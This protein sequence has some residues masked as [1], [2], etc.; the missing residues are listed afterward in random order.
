MELINN[1][2]ETA[3]YLHLEN[4][5]QEIKK[6]KERKENKNQLLILPVVG[7]FSSGKTT[8]INA[9][10]NSK[11][12]ETASKATTSVIYEIFFGNDKDNGPLV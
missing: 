7:E 12:L 2:L 4:T 3:Q 9:L 6:L 11:K 8:L 5:I 1:L 10:T